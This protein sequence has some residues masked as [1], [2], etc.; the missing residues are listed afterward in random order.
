MKKAYLLLLGFLLMLHPLLAFA[1]APEGYVDISNNYWVFYEPQEYD[2][3]EEEVIDIA[4]Q[5]VEEHYMPL[6]GDGDILENCVVSA[7]YRLSINEDLGEHSR[8]WRVLIHY[9]GSPYH[10]LQ[11]DIDSPTGKIDASFNNGKLIS[12][13]A[14]LPNVTDMEAVH[15]A[16]PKL[17]ENNLIS[18]FPEELKFDHYVIDEVPPQQYKYAWGMGNMRILPLKIY[19]KDKENNIIEKE[20]YISIFYLGSYLVSTDKWIVQLGPKDVETIWNSDTPDV[21]GTNSIGFYQ[22]NAY[23]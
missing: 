7:F 13:K 8:Y 15:K 23:K 12:L 21:Q 6:I 22:V 17:I 16:L 1:D 18:S 20:Y 9:D 10:Y 5:Y 3:T 14:N 19:F 11:F 4:W 2:L